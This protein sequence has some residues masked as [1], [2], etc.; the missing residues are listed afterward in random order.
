MMPVGITMEQE[1]WCKHKGD[2]HF[3]VAAH[4]P[5][6]TICKELCCPCCCAQSEWVA[7]S[8]KMKYNLVP[9]CCDCSCKWVVSVDDEVV[10]KIVDMGPCDNGCWFCMCPCLTCDGAIKIAKIVDSKNNER[11]TI[12][13]ELFCCWPCSQCCSQ[14]CLPFAMFSRSCYACCMYCSDKEM[15][16]ITQPVYPAWERGDAFVPELGRLVQLMRWEPCCCCMAL[17]TPT[18]YFFKINEQMSIDD[19]QLVRIGM[20][21]QLYRGLPH[22][23][24]AC[25]CGGAKF[26]QPTGL[27]CL[28][29][30]LNT[31]TEWYSVKDAE[32]ALQGGSMD[33]E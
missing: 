5:V 10:G 8:A 7:A 32:I 33:T 3:F 23:C 26:Q 21:L 25:G 19:Q 15:L 17:P 20:I 12:Q 2:V 18:K 22:P 24:K 16:F 1:V 29:T 28:D 6:T 31:T 14:F 30:G 13:K 4:K 9:N 11:I 27:S